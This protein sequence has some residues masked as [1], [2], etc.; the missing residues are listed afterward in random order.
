MLA[1]NSLPSVLRQVL[2]NPQIHKAGH[3]VSTDLKYLQEAC[4]SATPFVGAVDLARL[5][6]ERHIIKAATAS[7]EDLSA[8][9][10]SKC[11][12]KNVSEHTSTAWENDVLTE[13]QIMYAALNAYASLLIYDALMDI[14]VPAPLPSDPSI[15]TPVMLFA[16]NTD[17]KLIAYGTISP[18]ST[19]ST[20]NGINLTKTRIV[21]DINKVLVPGA[22]VTTHRNRPVQSFGP[23]VFSVVCL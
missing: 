19:E 4:N 17:N 18:H 9:V 7:L 8:I 22:I 16:D 5:A 3:A 1:G 15:D 11:L 13:Q 23:P 21:L 10:L 6:K 12:N 14:P 20:F 2:I